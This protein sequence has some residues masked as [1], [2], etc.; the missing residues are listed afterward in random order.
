M[1]RSQIVTNCAAKGIW[2]LIDWTAYVLGLHEDNSSNSKIR[3]QTPQFIT[4]VVDPQAF[5]F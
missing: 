4:G 2:G 1:S 3:N 5:N